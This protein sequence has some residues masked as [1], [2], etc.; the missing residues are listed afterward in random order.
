[1]TDQSNRAS[2]FQMSRGKPLSFNRSGVLRRAMELFWRNGYEATGISELIDHMGIPRQS[3]YNTFGNKEEVFFESINLYG[4]ILLKILQET[5][6][7][8]RTP[9]KKIDRL[10]DMWAQIDSTRGCLLGNCMAEFGSSHAGVSEIMTKR[11][12]VLRDFFGDIFQDA[13]DRGDLPDNR[14]PQIMA[15]TIITYSQGLALMAKTNPSKELIQGTIGIMKASLR[16]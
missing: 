1:L 2:M 7:G 4:D 12:N 11:F 9:F 10:F 5:V 15:E 3:F 8:S 16:R 13:I 14:N 6:K